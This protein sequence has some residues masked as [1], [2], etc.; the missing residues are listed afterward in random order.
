MVRVMVHVSGSASGYGS[1]FFCS[2]HI[3]VQIRSGQ[4]LGLGARVRPRVKGSDSEVMAGLSID[5]RIGVGVRARGWGKGR[6]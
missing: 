4:Q 2:V 3:R 6:V 5:F 1:C